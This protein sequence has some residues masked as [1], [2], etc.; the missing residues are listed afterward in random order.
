MPKHFWFW[1]LVASTFALF[2]WALGAVLTPFL[3][4][5]LLAYALYP[6]VQ[7]LRRL[8]LPQWLCVTV[9][10]I[11]FVLT[12][13]LLCLLLLPI[14][15]KEW[16]QLQA[17]LPQLFSQ[18]WQAIMPLMHEL[19]LNPPVDEAA[20]RQWVSV[21][22][23]ENMSDWSKTLWASARIGGS[24]A[25]TVIG[26]AVLIPVVLFYL[27]LD[28]Q[29]LL[30]RAMSLVPRQRV[31]Q[32][33]DFAFETNSVLGQY[34]RGQ[35]SVMGLLAI[36]YSAG[37]YLF[38]FDLA[39]P[40]GVFTGLAVFIPYV[41]FG[42]GLMLAV[43]SALLQFDSLMGLVG[44]A[45]VYGLG[46]VIEGFFLTPRLVGQRIGLH[47]VSVIFAL[48]AFGQLFGFVGVL[49]AL[50]MSAVLLVAIRRALAAYRASPLFLQH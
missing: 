1:L 45:V 25:L 42:L 37:L 20:L 2:V 10:E 8:G 49:L 6:A 3:T 43:L 39:L 14:L 19:G 15:S 12:L 27:L 26:N 29:S 30:Q 38:G 34:L 32:V 23:N 50:P 33:E 40:L 28:W 7:A 16:P 35:L 18:S 48:L 46:Q 21:T 4:A 9:V 41:G 44:V 5:T 13:I 47:P 24:M 36:Y 22:L 31:A 11:A 17:Q